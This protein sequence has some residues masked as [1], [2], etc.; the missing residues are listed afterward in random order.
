MNGV[1]SGPAERNSGISDVNS[2]PSW[3]FQTEMGLLKSVKH[4]H[5]H[6]CTCKNVSLTSLLTCL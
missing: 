4:T 2:F 1:I 3:S 5:T 6:T